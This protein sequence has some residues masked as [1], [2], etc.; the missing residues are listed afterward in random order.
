MHTEITMASTH[1]TKAAIADINKMNATMS[2]LQQYI[3]ELK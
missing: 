3:F 1:F 2:S